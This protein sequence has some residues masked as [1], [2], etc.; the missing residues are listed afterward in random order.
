MSSGCILKDMKDENYVGVLLEEIRD[1]N[2]AV[3]E[4]VGQIKDE[5][6]TLA[7]KDALQAVADDVQTIK[8]VLT[9]TNKDLAGLNR[10]VTLL[11]QTS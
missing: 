6:K 8:V 5:V 3:L 2:K 9:E 4:V 10:R 7:T 11:E 1:Q